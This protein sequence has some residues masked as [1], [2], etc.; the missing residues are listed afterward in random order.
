MSRVILNN[1]RVELTAE[2]ILAVVRQLPPKEREKIRHEL[3]AEEWKR[4][5]EALLARI[6]A[7][8]DQSPISEEEIDR[9]VQ[10]VRE[11]RRARRAA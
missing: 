1:V 10:A 7:R 11:A 4:D 2:Q 6:H 3:E 5:F 8:V 9:E